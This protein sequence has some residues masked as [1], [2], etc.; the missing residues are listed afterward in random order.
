MTIPFRQ[1]AA[2]P[3]DPALPRR[4]ALVVL[5]GAGLAPVVGCGGKMFADAP[6]LDAPTTGDGGD[7]TPSDLDAGATSPID[8]TASA[9][10]VGRAPPDAGAAAS[11]TGAT[12]CTPIGAPLGATADFPLQT[13]TGVSAQELI[14]GHDAGGLF[15]YSGICTHAGC[16]MTADVDRSTGDVTCPCHT[17]SFDGTGACIT[18]AGYPLAHF[19]LQSCDGQLYVDKSTKVS[20]TTRTAP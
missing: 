15:A 17:W 19:A 3:I 1:T 9:P 14:V 11:D 12:S 20:S 6:S 7:A 5:T 16:L 13:W 18:R 10:D 4:R 2:L 8:A